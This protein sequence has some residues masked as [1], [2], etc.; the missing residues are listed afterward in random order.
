MS[1]KS[2]KHVIR[3]GQAVITEVTGD[4]ID[5]SEDPA[6]RTKEV[7]IKGKTDTRTY[8]VPYSTYESSRRR[9]DPPWCAIDE[10]SIV[11]N[12]CCKFAMYYL[13]KTTL[14]REVQRVYRMQRG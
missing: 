10:G 12:N 13:L 9:Y 14:L 3:K 4:V 11:Q 1:K 8:T 5:I 6:T 2:L 7:T